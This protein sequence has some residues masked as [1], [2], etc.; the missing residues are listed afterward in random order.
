M[1]VHA[2]YPESVSAPG[3]PPFRQGGSG[4]IGMAFYW[5]RTTGG[6]RLL[7]AFGFASSVVLP[8][9]IDG[10]PLT[11]I[12]AYCFSES[13]HLPDTFLRS[14]T[15]E[16]DDMRE[17]SGRYIEAVSLPDTVQKIGNL[18]FYNCTSLKVLT[19]GKHMESPGSDVFMNCQKLRRIILRCGVREKSGIRPI[20]SR[21][22]WEILITFQK[23]KNT[24]AELLFPEYYESY[25]EIAPAHLFG[26]SVTGEG[27]RARQCFKDNVTDFAQYD[28]IFP[29]A[30]VEEP[31]GTLCRFALCR[32]RYPTDLSATAR[33][34][35]ASFLR[36][37]D[38]VLCRMAVEARDM[39]QVRFLCENGWM[40][41][42]ALEQGILA[43]GKADWAKGAAGLL[44]L[45]EEFFPQ[46]IQ[47]D[48]YTF[49][50][51]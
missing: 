51:F 20:L 46:E 45:K 26:R 36:E 9:E 33:E 24:E 37:H 47:S 13:R 1:A 38:A 34:R 2:F 18:A 4:N 16:L 15:E 48:P 30:C 14:Q 17:L 19:V 23:D 3:S 10:V 44:R 39:E 31:V 32:L 8:D 49:D 7:R 41:R 21:I 40:G 27:F 28:L 22:S 25:D 29:K 35:Y 50:D 6:A 12:G 5:E 43:A 11:E 42:E